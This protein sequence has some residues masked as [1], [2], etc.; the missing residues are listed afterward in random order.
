MREP[1]YPYF[2][3]IVLEM[4]AK[5]VGHYHLTPNPDDVDTLEK[6][7]EYYLKTNHI[8]VWTGASENTIFGDPRLNWAFRAWHDLIHVTNGEAFT[9]IGEI[10]VA[11]IQCHQVGVFLADETPVQR[12]VVRS[13][14]MCEVVKQAQYFTE[15]GR[16]PEDQ[17][18]FTIDTMRDTYGI[19]FP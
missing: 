2:N 17:V 5:H 4:C 19:T 12:K 18:Q 14:I 11:A 6:V 8:R 3:E 9:L 10:N 7:Q 1:L 16:F 15:H 13:L